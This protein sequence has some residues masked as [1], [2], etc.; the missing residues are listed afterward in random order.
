[1]FDYI[2]GSLERL[3]NILA[4]VACLGIISILG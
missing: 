4:I 3:I 2:L 1:M